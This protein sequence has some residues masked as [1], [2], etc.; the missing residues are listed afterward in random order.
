MSMAHARLT[1]LVSSLATQS[2]L[3]EAN[4]MPPCEFDELCIHYA[5][6][7]QLQR[8]FRQDLMRSWDRWANREQ[9]LD[10]CETEEIRKWTSR[11][12]VIEFTSVSL[13]QMVLSFPSDAERRLQLMRDDVVF[14]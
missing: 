4:V 6:V 8:N 1:L 3:G 9:S 5:D 13:M 12:V 10:K 14:W 11:H 2:L 7:K